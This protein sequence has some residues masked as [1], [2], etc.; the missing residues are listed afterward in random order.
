MKPV[1][2]LFAALVAL[3]V[4]S[5]IVEAADGCGRGWYFNGRRCVPQEGPP[6]Y[7]PPPPG[8]PGVITG[9]RRDTTR[10][11]H[12]PGSITGLPH[13]PGLSCSLVSATEM[14]R[15]TPRRILP[16]RHGT[17]AR[18][19]SQFRMGC[20]SRTEGAKSKRVGPVVAVMT[21]VAQLR[22]PRASADRGTTS[23]I[24]I[25]LKPYCPKNAV[26]GLIDGRIPN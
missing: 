5:T 24:A 26:D 9:R 23:A 15:G 3:S 7:G 17:T 10:L 1:T 13:R 19:I 21:A 18:R 2:G 20:V 25:G 4:V 12:R 8:P 6:G 16:L 22:F 14:R 11:P